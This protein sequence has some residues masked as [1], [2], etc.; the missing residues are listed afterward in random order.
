MTI[1]HLLPDAPQ[2]PGTIKARPEDF[3]VEELP[4]YEPSG[5][6]EHLMLCI[7]KTNLATQDALKI[8]A[9]AAQVSRSAV[10]YAGMKDK[11]AVTRQ[12]ITI[13]LPGKAAAEN[14]NHIIS[15]IS[16]PDLK[17]IWAMRHNNKLR[18]GHLAGNR[19]V[20][21]VRNTRPTDVIHAK[22]ALE[23][24]QTRGIPN[25]FGPQRFGHHG[26]NAQLGLLLL[27]SDH[28]AFLDAFLGTPHPTDSDPVKQAAAAY[29][30]KDYAAAISLLPRGMRHER[31]ALDH[32]RQHKT[33]EQAIKAIDPL[34]RDFL[35]SALQSDVFNRT[36]TA[37]IDH[38]SF[39]RLIPGDLAFLHA[40]RAVFSVDQPTA[41]TENTPPNGRIHT[42]EISP[43]GPMWGHKM[44]RPTDQALT[45][46]TQVLSDLSLTPDSF[47]ESAPLGMI[48][49][50]RRPLRIP[51]QNPQISAGVDEHGSYIKFTFDL[52]R[53]GYA[54]TVLE[55]VMKTTFIDQAAED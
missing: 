45:L 25:Y 38:G 3:L 37:R 47:P 42:F 46:E 8:I 41:T 22:R 28:Q 29:L 44:L 50:E 14:D 21:R 12:H 55:Q 9:R 24:L 10:G 54:T 49:G 35:M 26:N 52:P 19:F 31:Q 15:Q 2:I 32:L 30:A 17:P 13:H 51:L 5:E 18:Q 36:L 27:K 34:Q 7:E 4:L 53:S 39:D 16:R 43:S 11:N 33:P 6:G 20:I 48:T 40:N 1:R 23:A